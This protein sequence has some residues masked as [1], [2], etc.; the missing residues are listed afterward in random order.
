[1]IWN[2]AVLKFAGRYNLLSDT[3]W[4][5]TQE[6]ISELRAYRESQPGR[7]LTPELF[8]R[9]VAWKLRRQRLRTE[10][11]RKPITAA[12]LASITECAFTL[13]HDHRR[14]LAA[15][16]T[17]VLASLPG[18]GTGLAS[19]IL[20]LVFPDTYAVVDFRVWRVIFDEKKLAFTVPDYLKYL[21]EIW[22]LSAETSWS[23]QKTDYLTW[24]YF[25]R[26]P[27]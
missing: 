12:M 7:G 14:T 3:D 13:S 2:Q 1:M 26:L 17:E 5:K 16:R 11:R 25:E 21:G 8:D 24:L 15:V 19:A 23:P 6:L 4:Q 9:I 10:G 22:Q 20:T 18:V 27:E